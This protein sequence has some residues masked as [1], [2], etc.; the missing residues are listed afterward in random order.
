MQ[1][2]LFCTRDA[3]VIFATFLDVIMSEE[4]K[5]IK[6]N[7][8]KSLMRRARKER[9]E[10][11]DDMMAVLKCELNTEHYEIVDAIKKVCIL[12]LTRWQIRT[13]ETQEQEIERVKQNA[14]KNKIGENLS[15]QEYIQTFGKSFG[16][17]LKDEYEKRKQREK[18]E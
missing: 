18:Q 11:I 4:K 2:T 7:W 15:V 8:Y 1:Y 17:E 6:I 12:E 14:L 5:V 9:I 3:C 10:M 16:D 13:D